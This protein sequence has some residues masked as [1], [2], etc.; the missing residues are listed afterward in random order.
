MIGKKVYHPKYGVGEIVDTRYRGLEYLVSFHIGIKKWVRFYEVQ[1]ESKETSSENTGENRNFKERSII[2]A[3]RLGIVPYR[4]IEE[5]TFGRKKEIQ[6]LKNWLSEK[7]NNFFFIIGE[8]GSGKTHLISYLEAMALKER[9]ATSLVELDL[10]ESPFFKPK[11][12]YRSIVKAFKYPQG[13]GK[14]GG[15]RTFIKEAL[16]L[17]YLKNH[18]YFKYLEKDDEILWEWIEAKDIY[19]K[20]YEPMFSRWGYIVNAYNYLP[21]LLDQATSLNVYCNL[22]ST[23]SWVA[24]EAFNLKGFLLIFD[25]AE[26]IN[27]AS[28][29]QK[30]KNNTFI[31]ALY[32]LAQN[33]EKLLYTKL[34][35]DMGF[36]VSKNPM[37]SKIGYIYKLPFN[38]K[39]TLA[40]TFPILTDK[41]MSSNIPYI[42][43]EKLPTEVLEEIFWRIWEIYQKAYNIS[44]EY[45][46]G[47]IFDKLL[48]R[49]DYARLFI[50]GV[51]EAFDLLSLED[52]KFIKEYGFL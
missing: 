11:R 19:A 48:E 25:E 31:K 50:K 7:K 37:A 49:K 9:F 30:E 40:F 33:D 32:H 12:V 3:L 26:S 21:P 28:P 43:L 41:K 34:A 1:L 23:I 20:P 14:I 6:K 44:E 16:K 4:Y 8:Y 51:I 45:F 29:S 35:K 2:E 42:T 36:Y 22:I 27:E 38:L 39:V 46:P 13:S 15:F 5:F 17:G 52:E 24:R 47:Y 10:N 18:P